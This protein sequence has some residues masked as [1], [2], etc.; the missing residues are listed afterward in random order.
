M[1][2]AAASAVMAVVVAG[3]GVL[4][5]DRSPAIVVATKVLVGGA[6]YVSAVRLLSADL[7]AELLG[8]V[9]LAGNRRPEDP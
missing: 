9:R 1:I 3:A 4:V 6:T 5:D 8:L 7:S 2:P